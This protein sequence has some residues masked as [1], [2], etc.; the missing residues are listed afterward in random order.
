MSKAKR[1]NFLSP[2]L[3]TFFYFNC[4]YG[5]A[6]ETFNPD[7]LS[8]GQSSGITI[9]DISKFNRIKYQPPGI[10]RVDV[11]VN[12]ENFF[13]KDLL[14]IEKENE[15]GEPYLFPCLDRGMIELFGVKLDK[16]EDFE[17]QQQQCMDFI[18]AVP[19]SLSEFVFEKHRLNLSFPQ[20]SIKGSAR[21]YIS[22]ERWDNGISALFTKYTM[23]A[24]NNSNSDSKSFFLSLNNG[25]N[26]KSWQF[27]SDTT[28]NYN[29]MPDA[30]SS[31]WRH[32]NIYVKK[33]IIPLKSKLV[34]GESNSNSDIFDGF[35]FRGI[36]LSS[37]IEM[38]PDS[39][40]GYAPT[41][42]G[43]ARTHANVVVKQNN[44]VVYQ[45]SVAPGP[46]VID[47][48]NPTSVSGDLKVE[49]NES[50]G[51]TQRFIVPYS[52]LPI[53]QREKR[54]N[55]NVMAGRYRGGSQNSND[56]NIFQG[57]LA[58]GLTSGTSLYG[59]TQVS[60]DYQSAILG[61]G[62]NLGEFGALSFDLT[63][64]ESQLQNG[65]KL[66]GQSLRFLYAKSLIRMGT[67]FRLLGYRYSTEGFY[68]LN[69]VANSAWSLHTME[70]PQVNDI[71]FASA[72]SKKGKFEVNISHAFG[73]KGA[74]FLS[75]TEQSYWGTSAKNSWV[76]AGYSTVLKDAS[77]S[78]SVSHLRNDVIKE[79]D[80]LLSVGISMP[81]E[82]LFRKNNR[83]NLFNNSYATVSVTNNSEGATAVQAGLAGTLL[84]DRNLRYS[85]MQGNREEGYMGAFSLDYQGRYGNIGGGYSYADANRQMSLNA[86]G[87]ALIHRNGIVF[88]QYLNQTS[89]L[90]EAKG[91]TGVSI[92]NHPGI[93]INS[94][95]FA[96]LPYASAYRANRVSLDPNSFSDN[97]EIENNVNI[98]IPANGAISR[99]I[100]K[101]KLGIRALITLYKDNEII[102]FASTVTE[103]H[104]S[105]SGIV[106]SD[107]GVYL[108]GLPEVGT[109]N[110]V[111]GTKVTDQCTIDYNISDIAVTAQP[112]LQV[113]L[114]C[115]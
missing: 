110:V 102:P 55:Y 51:S 2:I 64:A 106:G 80:T 6:E 17:N 16:E 18:L 7:F 10:Y 22:P 82:R 109:L 114:S 19:G 29:S 48:L 57:T 34:I 31:D 21:G 27:R 20:A 41:V 33:N 96:L 87:S 105:A 95:G 23:S 32:I 1:K 98:I 90:V 36:S 25:F 58:Y 50:D 63:H 5:F 24:Y 88:G 97:L 13:T 79:K 75:G 73:N 52:T 86:S 49:I 37:A 38:Y 45:I 60:K 43:I 67:T 30:S 107:G 3:L 83:R 12:G 81:L 74:I 65:L 11:F 115:Q 15:A 92:E 108:T 56:L 54:A 77:I 94:K 68:T 28:F 70:V 93:K 8:D 111:W 101:T 47:D 66:S 85:I 69:E 40:Q 42:R 44:Y 46:F 53:L 71:S 100:F 59:G 89:I 84:E 72:L 91:A 9:S 76:Q 103:T 104:S 61:I 112:I 35:S 14:F 62:R 26:I 78:L 4:S 39:Q 99:A 113:D